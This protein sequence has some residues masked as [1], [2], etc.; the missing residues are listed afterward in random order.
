MIDTMKSIIQERHLQSPSG[1]TVTPQAALTGNPNALAWRPETDTRPLEDWS[2]PHDAHLGGLD[3]LSA[4]VS[5]SEGRAAP[6][7]GVGPAHAP[8]LDTEGALLP[9]NPSRPAL[10]HPVRASLASWK[11]ATAAQLETQAKLIPHGRLR[12][13]WKRKAIDFRACGRLTGLVCND[14]SDVLAASITL[15]ASCGLR[16][17]PTCARRRASALR[18]KL[19]ACW[20]T[21]EHPRDMSLYLITL[22]LRYDPS[23]EDDLSVE[24]IRRRKQVLIHAWS[25]LWRRYLKPRG[26]AAVRAV[27]VGSHGLVHIH[28]LY[29]GRRPDVTTLRALY[30][31]T[32]G[33]S[34]QIQVDYV[35]KPRNA[36]TELA[37]YVTK[38]ASPAKA[39]TLIGQPAEFIDPILAARVELAFAGDR[40]VE[41]YGA[42]RGVDPD[43]D[44]DEPKEVFASQACQRCGSVGRWHLAG[45]QRSDLDHL[46]PDFRAHV[47]RFAPDPRP[48][49]SAPAKGTEHEERHDDRS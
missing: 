42:W 2:S 21:S 3:A 1:L 5:D 40:L 49:R 20:E 37:K 19:V 31:M 11:S 7:E 30:M 48:P 23:N 15:I 46:G 36:I 39:R 25:H 18:R 9:F 6:S 45:L 26:R 33:D 24:G 22:T 34:P 27:E 17:C 28:A 43:N 4:G 44:E 14:C 32:V 29:H 13:S 12:R 35:R 47:G 38:G 10:F 41:S 16:I 8:R